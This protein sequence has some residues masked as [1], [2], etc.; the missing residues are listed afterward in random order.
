MSL[1]EMRK[2][3]QVAG[4]RWQVAGGR[5]QV[6]GG[7]WQVAGGRWQVAGGSKIIAGTFSASRNFHYFLS[8]QT[9]RMVPSPWGGKGR[10]N[11]S[12]LLPV[13]CLF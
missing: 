4:G 11:Q 7:R 10:G 3:G 6:A 9:L 2:K 1:H 5:W 13:T 8:T 12:I